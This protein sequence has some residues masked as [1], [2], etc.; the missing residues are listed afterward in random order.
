[1]PRL[2][3]EKGSPPLLP[4]ASKARKLLSIDQIPEWYAENPFIRTG[5]RPVS[6]SWAACLGSWLHVHNQTAN[7]A[8]HLVPAV[9]AAGGNAWL[10]Q[11]FAA[12]YPGAG[13][14][15]RAV[16]HAYLT[17]CAL[18]FGLSAAYHT[19][20]CHSRGAAD[21]WVRLDYAGISV[22][23]LGS[24]VPGLYL[25][26]Y[27]EPGLQALYLGMVREQTGRALM[28]GHENPRCADDVCAVT[29]SSPWAGSTSTS[30]STTVSA[31]RT[32]SRH[33][34]CRFWGW[35][36]RPSSPSSTRLSSSPTTSC[37]SRP[38]STTTI[39]RE[40]AC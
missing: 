23:I 33:A 1:M 4:A 7:I 15:D 21:L 9:L 36:S 40:P 11:L 25:G 5:Y 26:F 32:G 30:P 29:R 20:L 38:G 17:A 13:A 18:C 12:S 6:G 34:C 10:R 19:L 8:T 22:L 14:A 27:C 37:R 2:G 3:A 35:A 24:F 31:P 39:S 16:F 28:M